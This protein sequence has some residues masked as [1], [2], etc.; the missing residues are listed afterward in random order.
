MNLK[1]LRLHLIL[2]RSSSD[3]FAMFCEAISFLV[4]RNDNNPEYI[5]NAPF[6]N[7]GEKEAEAKLISSANCHHSTRTQHG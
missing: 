3:S 2:L 6:N 5:I 1:R 7:N 4:K